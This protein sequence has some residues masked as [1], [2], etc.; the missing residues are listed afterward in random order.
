MRGFFGVPK[1]NTKPCKNRKIKENKSI[2]FEPFAKTAFSL[3]FL[4]VY[5]FCQLV[6]F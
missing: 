2:D 4:K 1:A 3:V 5:Y 6:H